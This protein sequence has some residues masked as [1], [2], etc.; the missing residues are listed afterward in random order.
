[1]AHPKKRMVNFAQGSGRAEDL[2]TDA[3]GVPIKAPA[4]N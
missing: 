4:P 3:S 2:E 1:M